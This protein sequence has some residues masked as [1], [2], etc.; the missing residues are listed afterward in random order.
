MWK[1]RW[2]MYLI[3]GIA[4]FLEMF[5]IMGLW[6]LAVLFAF[7]GVLYCAFLVEIPGMVCKL[8]PKENVRKVFLTHIFLSGALLF[9]FL[10]QMKKSFLEFIAWIYPYLH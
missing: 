7:F 3:G 1:K 2:I 6:K 9:I 8:F 10:Y 5:F 4:V